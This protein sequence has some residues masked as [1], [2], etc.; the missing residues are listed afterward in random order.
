MRTAVRVWELNSPAFRGRWGVLWVV[1]G[2]LAVF[3]VLWSVS[4]EI[5]ALEENRYPLYFDWEAAIPFQPWA[6]IFYLPHDLIVPL[7]AIIFRSWREALPLYATLLVQTL[8]AVPFFLL[9]PI[10]PGYVNDMPTGVWG[11]Y[12]FEPLGMKNLGQWNH[13]PSLHVSYVFLMAYIIGQ[14][15]GTWGWVCGMAWAVLVALTTMLVHEH[16]L[17]CVVSGFVLFLVTAFGVLPWFKA[18]CGVGYDG[19][20]S[21]R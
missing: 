20:E 13:M 10:E 21:T 2:F 11:A 1:V 15:W 5:S 7:M 14:R 19:R 17:I 3:G 16:H 8:I 12:I 18:R 6:M 9:V 4:N